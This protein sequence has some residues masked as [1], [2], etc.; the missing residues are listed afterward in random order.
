MYFGMKERRWGPGRYLAYCTGLLIILALRNFLILILIPSLLAWFIAERTRFR[1]VYIFGFMA[2]VFTLFF[3]TV[4]Y[5]V[6]ALDLPQAVVV[7]QQEFLRLKGKS[8]VEVTPLEPN[9][10]SFVKN[11]P[12]AISVSGLRPYPTDVHQPCFPW[13]RL[14]KL[15]S[16]F[17]F[18]YYS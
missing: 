18:L 13:D 3:F 16:C 14:L 1:P 5:V 7:K 4:R 17:C 9:F 10:T 8:T 12:E 15:I 6:P 2:V 11:A